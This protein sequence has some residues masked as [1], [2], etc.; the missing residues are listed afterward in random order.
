MHCNGP[1]TKESL[2][3]W[4]IYFVVGGRNNYIKYIDQ[5]NDFDS[6]SFFEQRL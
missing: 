1:L 2:R 3:T 4:P 6:G 5:K